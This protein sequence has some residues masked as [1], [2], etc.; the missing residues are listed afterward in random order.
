MKKLMRISRVN[1]IFSNMLNNP[2]FN[3]QKMMFDGNYYDQSHFIKDFKELTGETPKQFF[4][5]NSH[6]CRILSGV[7]KEDL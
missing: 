6:L 1:F 3:A 7:F 4:K 2:S 5:H